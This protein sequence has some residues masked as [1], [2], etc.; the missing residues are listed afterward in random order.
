MKTIFWNDYVFFFSF[1]VV[2]QS[3]LIL[4][5]AYIHTYIYERYR[6]NGRLYVVIT[7]PVFLLNDQQSVF[8]LTCRNS[9]TMYF[10]W[11]D[12]RSLLSTRVLGINS[13]FFIYNN[14]IE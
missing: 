8:T 4:F 2:K 11:G 10:F 5:F 3:N 14:L 13:F 6:N 9:L 12:L 1:R 7:T